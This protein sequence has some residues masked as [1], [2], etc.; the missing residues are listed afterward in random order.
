MVGREARAGWPFPCAPAGLIP[1][2]RRSLGQYPQ[3]QLIR[4]FIG[5]AKPHTAQTFNNQT[6]WPG[7]WGHTVRCEPTV[8]TGRGYRA[9]CP[10][11]RGLSSRD[12]HPGRNNEAGRVVRSGRPVGTGRPGRTG[13]PSWAGRAGQF[14]RPGRSDL[15]AGMHGM[16]PTWRTKY[17]RP[18][19]EEDANIA[20]R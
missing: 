7:Q 12:A 19:V 13:R 15:A 4:D 14:W 20:P 5:F 9:G 8:P 17:H 10:R 2:R 6:C 3:D 1:F 16:G 11:R 18:G